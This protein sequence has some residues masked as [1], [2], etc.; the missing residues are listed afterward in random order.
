MTRVACIGGFL[1]AG[2][3]TAIIQAARELIRRDLQVGVI[4]NDQGHHLVDTELIRSL[5]FPA[6]EVGGGCFCCRFTEFARHAEQ[7]V[8]QSQVDI[9]LAEAVG[10]CTDLSATVC[11]RL[12]R[13]HAGQFVVAPLTVMVDPGRVREMLRS[14]PP[15]ND[16]VRYLFGKQLAEADH[17]ILTKTDLLGKAEILAIQEEIGQLL[18]EIPVSV[19]SAKNGSGINEWVNLLVGEPGRGRQVQVDYDRYGAAEA[20]MGWLNAT[21]DLAAHKE[22]RCSGVGEALVAQM[23]QACRAA[24]LPIAHLKIMFIT[25]EGS[26]WIALTD[27][28][29]AANWGAAVELAPCRETSMIIN[30]RVCA[31][32]DQLQHLVEDAVRQTTSGRGIVATVHHLESFAPSPPV[33][34]EMASAS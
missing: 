34:P 5:G 18:G 31:R 20:A 19:M 29:G 9:I 6:E 25:A 14:R 22:F 26:D 8:E 33:R 17:I 13:S 23:Q 30:A 27:T 10:S 11:R 1:G 7:L 4:T 15:F 16:D 32:P 12:Q 2:K 24:Q 21:I 3:T 28:D